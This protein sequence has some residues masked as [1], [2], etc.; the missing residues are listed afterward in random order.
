MPSSP[1]PPGTPPVLWIDIIVLTLTLTM[2]WAAW[3][4]L[5]YLACLP[6]ALWAWWRDEEPPGWVLPLIEWA[7]R[8]EWGP[9]DLLSDGF[10][11]LAV[12]VASTWARIEARL[13]P[14]VAAGE[15][16]DDDG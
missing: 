12:T 7:E 9:T 1:T 15:G 16:G 10:A 2:L 14:T 3:L 13:P 8:V 4:L 5:V 11:W 6:P